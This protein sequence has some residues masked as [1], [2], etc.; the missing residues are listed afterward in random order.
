MNDPQTRSERAM[1]EAWRSLKPGDRVRVARGISETERRLVGREFV[2]DRFAK[3]HGYAVV[4]DEHG[5][6]HVH[7]EAL[8]VACH[9]TYRLEVLNDR[10]VAPRPA[11]GTDWRALVRKFVEDNGCAMQANKFADG[12]REL[13]P[14]GIGHPV[15][16]ILED[17]KP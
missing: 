2:F 9:S 16:R 6:W 8:E 15:A 5:A 11:T 14:N 4:E 12:T 3:P 10:F 1:A 7:P 13:V 17:W